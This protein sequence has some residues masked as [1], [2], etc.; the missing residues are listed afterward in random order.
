[1]GK[2]NYS[3]DKTRV[4][5]IMRCHLIRQSLVFFSFFFFTTHMP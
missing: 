4:L 2:K 5:V 1:M 3:V